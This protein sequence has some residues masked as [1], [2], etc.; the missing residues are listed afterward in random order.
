MRIAVGISHTPWVP[1]R[2]ASYD[3]LLK[4]LMAP[5][6]AYITT[7]TRAFTDK[8][9][10]WQWSAAM[11]SWAAS[12]DA[13]WCV[14]LQ[15]DAVIAPDF[16]RQFEAITKATTSPVIGLQVAHP[17]SV[18]L[19]EEG[20]SS[21]TTCEAVVGVGYAV[22]RLALVSFLEWRE[23]ELIPGAIVQITEDTL[24]GLWAAVTGRNVYHPIPT[25][26]D[27]DTSI[28]STYGNDNHANRHSRVRWDNYMPPESL[29]TGVPHMGRFYNITPELARRFVKGLEEHQYAALAQDDGASEARRLVHAK[30]AR[31]KTSEARVFIATPTRGGVNANYAATVWRLLK[32]EEF[33]TSCALEICDVQEWHEDVVRV[34]SRF[35]HYFLTRTTATHMLFLDSDIGMPPKVLRGMLAAGKDFVACPMPRRDVIDLDRVQR[36]AVAEK[37]AEKPGETLR[38]TP[39]E[40]LAYRYCLHFIDDQI[41]CMKDGTAE[42]DKVPLGC[43]LISRAGAQKLY[44]THKESLRFRDEPWGD[45]VALFSLI[46]RDGILYSEDYSFCIRWRESGMPIHCY[47]GDGSPVDHYGEHKYAGN[48]EAFGLRR[49]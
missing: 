14:F 10:N 25:I 22:R 15:D 6:P 12:T 26:V 32:D 23:V 40:A 47:F 36:T 45:S 3:R 38:L 46:H 2:V 5:I 35:L 28:P 21:F 7:Q 11:W 9:A 1:E 39:P 34:R 31:G 8:A 19:A 43:A 41:V 42:V 49:G 44:D 30:R 20:F 37:A 13:D 29:R 4:S 33:D 17:A 27:H 16:F 18:L 24:V 48:I